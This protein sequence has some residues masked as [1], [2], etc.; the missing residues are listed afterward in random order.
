MMKKL[1]CL[2][3]FLPIAAW[4][5]TGA[6]TFQRPTV[7]EDGSP[8]PPAAITGYEFVCA[9]GTTAGVAC[10]TLSLPGTALGGTMTITVPSSGGTACINGR[11]FVGT[12]ASQPSN[13]ACKTFAAIPPGPPTNVTVAVVI[14]G[15]EAPVFA[16]TAENVRLKDPVGFIDLGQVCTGPVLFTYRGD[17]YR[18]VDRANVRAW[19]VALT[20]RVA[21]PCAPAVSVRVNL[22]A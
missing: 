20:S 14:G 9:A 19:D 8:L 10:Q 3:V 12:A 13:I 17:K 6:I 18:R 7:Y 16:Y 22:N 5:A 21:A 1:A 4:A 11:A 15:K 2:L